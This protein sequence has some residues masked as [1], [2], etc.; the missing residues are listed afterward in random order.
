MKL[1]KY[2]ARIDTATTTMAELE[3][4]IKGLQ[5]EIAEMDAAVG[6]AAK[7]RTEEHEAFVK[8][9]SDYSASAKAVAAAIQVLKS[10]YEGGSFIQVKAKTG[11]V[12]KQPS[13]GGSSSDVGG[14]IVSVLEVA[15]SDFSTL[16]AESE[17]DEQSAAAAFAKLSDE[18]KVTKASK[19]AEIKGKQSEVRSLGVNRQNY[20]EDKAAVG[21]ELDAVRGYF[22]NDDG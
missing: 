11:L 7:I 14:T 3:E 15:E 16:L 10:Y 21:E 6:E 2:S 8:A 5:G 22:W 1:D 17:T 12:S 18:T 13:F 20:N 4:A 19:E 9:S